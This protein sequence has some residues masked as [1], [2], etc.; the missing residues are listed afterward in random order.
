MP[1]ASALLPVETIGC[2]GPCVIHQP[3]AGGRSAFPHRQHEWVCFQ[4]TSHG[5]P[6]DRARAMLLVPPY[7]SSFCKLFN[8]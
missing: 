7:I 6:C 8:S 5:G 2:L 4:T 3:S 1:E